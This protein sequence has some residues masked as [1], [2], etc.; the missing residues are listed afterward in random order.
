MKRALNPFC[1]MLN[2]MA[3]GDVIATVPVIKYL[4]EN[5]YQKPEL[6]RV[7]AK[8][9]F[10]PFFHFL[11]PEVLVDFDDPEL[12]KVNWGIPQSFAMGVLNQ[13]KV[14]LLVRNTPKHMHLAQ[15]ASI[16]FADSIL[17]LTDLNYVPLR[18]VDISHLGVDPSKSVIF[19]TT[20]RDYVRSLHADH[21][22]KCAEF[23][24]S[25]GYTPVYVGKTE[26]DQDTHL[27]PKTSLPDV[28]PIGV[29]LRNKTSIEELA[30]LMGYSKAV[31]GVDSGPIHL[32]GTTEVP[33]VCG[34]TSV[35]AEH[36]IP[37]R[38]RGKTYPVIPK[39]PCIG[40]ES[41]W[42]SHFWNFENCNLGTDEC[43]HKM[44]A[45]LFIPIL[46]NLLKFRGNQ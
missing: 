44:T 8:K 33:I 28:V 26:M 9:A 17:P 39:I 25:K 18:E 13:P 22:L 14:N 38:K 34:Y 37:I 30:T 46:N 20:Y 31:V 1:F 4:V 7:V 29:D 42:Q 35:L 5:Y 23:V 24:Q 10:H 40:C 6:Y 19:V 16:K 11:P 32:A 3:M 45:D 43:F 36:R 41:N 12:K 2:S 27:K 21:I 15:F